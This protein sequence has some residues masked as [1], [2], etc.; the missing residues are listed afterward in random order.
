M[1]KRTLVYGNTEKEL[2]SLKERETTN[3][4]ELLGNNTVIRDGLNVAL[5][6]VKYCVVSKIN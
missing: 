4:N 2:Y 3:N 1:D 5:N 6:K